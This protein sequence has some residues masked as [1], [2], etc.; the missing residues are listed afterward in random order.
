VEAFAPRPEGTPVHKEAEITVIAS[1]ASYLLTTLVIILP[2]LVLVLLRGR[3][4][5]AVAWS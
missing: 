3:G 5:P 1:L 2:L 4:P